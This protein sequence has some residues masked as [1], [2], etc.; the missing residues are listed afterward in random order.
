MLTPNETV[1]MC[2]TM[3][4]F[5]GLTLHPLCGG[6]PIDEAWSSIHLAAEAVLPELAA[7]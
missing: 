1:E 5:D 6:M 2:K 7:S 4:P 3:G